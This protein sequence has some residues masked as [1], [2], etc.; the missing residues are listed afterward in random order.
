MQ[1]RPSL[2]RDFFDQVVNKGPNAFAFLESLTKTTPPTFESDWLDFKGWWP[3]LDNNKVKEIWST[4]L[5]GF[6][7]NQGG[8]L[9]WGIKADKTDGIDAANGLMLVPD[10]AKLATRLLELNH[11]ATDP[12]VTGIE[13]VPIM[14][15]SEKN[16]FV[17]CFLPE[18]PFAPHRAELCVNKPFF[19][20]AGDDF[21]PAGV[22]ML[23]R[24]FYPQHQNYLV[25]DIVLRNAPRP[26]VAFG[27]AC[28]MRNADM[29]TAHDVIVKVTHSMGPAGLK[30]VGRECEDFGQDLLKVKQPIHQGIGIT[31]CSFDFNEAM[32]SIPDQMWIA[33]KIFG[34]DTEPLE[35]KFEISREDI[36]SNA[37]KETSPQMIVTARV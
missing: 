7:N 28:R 31:F 25:P 37:I 32:H 4:A 27:F 14:P 24:L 18:S 20:R 21:V 30:G 3:T 36:L 17:V 13:V 9:I 1:Y 5:S 6:A 11:V 8:V 2:A 12:P 35:W 34:R 26:A 33:V 16:G 10:A 15:G 19:I 23:R 29:L 22:S